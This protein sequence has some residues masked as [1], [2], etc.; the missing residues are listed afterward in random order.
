MKMEYAFFLGCQIPARLQQ[1]ES[2]SRAVLN[3]LGIKVRD[4]RQF[5]CC[6]YPMRNSNFKAFLI[7]SVRNLAL[8][9]KKELNILTLCKCCYGSLKKAEHCMKTEKDLK[10]E[11]NTIL[12]SEGLSYNGKTTVRHL[13]TILYK[14]IGPEK[15]KKKINI[16]FRD[17]KIATHY[18]CHAL[19]PSDITMFDDPV[20][21]VLFDDL[22][23]LT[24]AVSV[25]RGG[26][27]ECCGSPA[28]GIN[29]DLSV[30]LARKRLEY[31]KNSGAKFVT[32]A[33]P[34]CQIQFDKVND[35]SLSGNG[36]GR[37]VKSVLF[38]QILGLSMGLEMVQ[39]GIDA[40]DIDLQAI[41]S[42]LDSPSN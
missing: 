39:L 7:S 33:C 20:N 29:D 11:V 25:T 40:N 19:R 38:S 4:I 35:R 12:K 18:G 41:G 2:S 31:Y 36:N 14:D 32:T 1:Y 28:M 27:L 13:L 3:E 22:V 42:F 24:G 10:E 15:I 26:S 37:I 5:N 30:S 23:E 8:A 17:L 21:P 9:E 16:P 34:Y 6:G